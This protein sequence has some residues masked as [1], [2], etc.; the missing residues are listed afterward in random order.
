M[1]QSTKRK[2]YSLQQAMKLILS[3]E[4]DD[5]DTAADTMCAVGTEQ[6]PNNEDNIMCTVGVEQPANNVAS[7]NT[8]TFGAEEQ[9]E[10]LNLINDLCVGQNVVI[11]GNTFVVLSA[12][13]NDGRD[14]L[15]LI[16]LEEYLNTQTGQSISDS[17]VETG[18]T[19]SSQSSADTATESMSGSNNTTTD[20][21]VSALGIEQPQ[22][23][24][25]TDNQANNN[26]ASANI[27]QLMHVMEDTIEHEAVHKPQTRKRQS[28]IASR[29]KEKRS[30]QKNAGQQYIN[31]SGVLH[32]A[33]TVG[34]DCNCKR[35]CFELVKE[36]HRDNICKSFWNL[37][38]FN[39]Q[40]AYLYG[41]I[42]SYNPL[43]RY[44]AS[45]ESRRQTSFSYHVTNADGTTARVC[46]QS[47]L[48]FHGLHQNRGRLGNIQKQ[49]ASGAGVPRP[50]QRGKHCNRPHRYSEDRLQQVKSHIE[51]FPRHQSHYSRRDNIDRTYLGS[52]LTI[53]EMYRLYKEHCTE[54]HWDP[55][56]EDFYRRTFCEQY[57][58]GF[59]TPRTDTCKVCDQYDVKMKSNISDADR[60]TCEQQWQSHK[61]KANKAFDLLRNLTSTAHDKPQELHTIAFDLEQA[62]PTPKLS[63]GPAF[64]KRK[65]YTYNLAVH[66]CG[67]NKANMM[68][69]PETVGGRGADE[70]GSCL[71]KYFQQPI[72]SRNLAVFSD[73][74]GGQN[75]N[76]KIMALWQY[77][78]VTDKFDEIVHYFPVSGHTMLPCDRDFGDIER[79]VRKHQQIYSPDEYV[80]IISNARRANPF[81]VHAM[82]LNE[83]KSLDVVAKC[84]MN[85]KVTVDGQKVKFQSVCQFRF[86]KHQL[87][88]M[89][90]KYSH[91][92][93]EP[94][95][96]VSMVKRGRPARLD[97]VIV[98]TK[99]TSER[100]LPKKKWMISSLCCLSYLKFITASTTAFGLKKAE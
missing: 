48:S 89:Q 98:P 52:D 22:N 30:R 18:S 9:A 84:L 26:V 83:F 81:I 4:S 97:Q 96:E 76:L 75:K 11:G 19:E 33:K 37:G 67:G 34:P 6:P 44:T 82:K 57:N 20:N 66:N 47:F 58:I 10:L 94:W 3:N 95:Q 43:R 60:A 78:I 90:I 49:I 99:C 74:C 62:L 41:N 25:A 100:K 50:D 1:D 45:A 14:T 79:S 46:K 5:N 91:D 53:S 27:S 17:A 63:C 42:N 93:V 68:I 16:P 61:T 7:D 54:K 29:I 87:Y 88:S 31:S 86:T 65:L 8:A 77:L 36:E 72:P 73:N 15:L 21:S 92:D 51:M 71:L 59:A 55:V 85:R 56:S 40:N 2:R 69:W 39:S 23:N 13:L 70:I 24:I 12:V 35:K 64:Y 32:I 28:D 80:K 38:N